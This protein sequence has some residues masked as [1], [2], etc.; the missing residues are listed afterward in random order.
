MKRPFVKPD[1]GA[2]SG[3]SRFVSGNILNSIVEIVQRFA[4]PLNLHLRPTF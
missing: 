2:C 3:S 1:P 4:G